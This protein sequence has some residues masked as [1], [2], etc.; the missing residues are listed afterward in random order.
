M[1]VD[2][3][4]LTT[5]SRFS[6]HRSNTHP[7][8]FRLHRSCFFVT[9]FIWVFPGSDVFPTSR[10]CNFFPLTLA[11][12]T[13]PTVMR[14]TRILCLEAPQPSTTNCSFSCPPLW[15]LTSS[16]SKTSSCLRCVFVYPFSLVRLNKVSQYCSRFFSFCITALG[17]LR[18]LS[19]YGL[20][21]PLRQ[22][23]KI[24]GAVRT[25]SRLLPLGAFSVPP[26]LQSRRWFFFST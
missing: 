3:S 10:L 16:L 11:T 7:N 25:Y 14:L 18:T 9:A 4:A 1:P 22:A 15:F 26:Q 17:Y 8:H 12:C 13:S 24:P 20:N 5:F 21:V 2:G 23:P 6:T 19:N